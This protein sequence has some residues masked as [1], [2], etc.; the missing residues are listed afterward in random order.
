[1]DYPATPCG[2]VI[3]ASV[4]TRGRNADVLVDE[5]VRYA[6]EVGFEPRF[7][8]E[9]PHEL[10]TT[11][12]NGTC[13]WLIRPAAANPWV[14][15]L[16]QRLPGPLPTSYLSLIGRYRFCNFEI[17][18]LMLFSNTGQDFHF[19]LSRAVFRDEGLFPILHTYGYLQF[20][21]PDAANYDPI[22][23]DSSRSD[24][25]DSPI[26]QLD[27]EEILIR[28]RIRIV[29]KIAPSFADFIQDAV[30]ERLPVA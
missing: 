18:P 21:K 30:T 8:D 27:H 19:E 11:E 26:V 15:D 10:R 28:S 23:F 24:R 2:H 20:G 22:C 3:V 25:G 5:F 1:M 4:S 14:E 16:K 17:G 9:V 6:N 7:E 12:E 13:R 29:R